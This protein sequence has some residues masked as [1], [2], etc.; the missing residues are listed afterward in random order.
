MRLGQGVPK[1]HR[2]IGPIFKSFFCLKDIKKLG[3][4]V[5]LVSQFFVRI[6]KRCANPRPGKLFVRLT[7]DSYSDHQINQTCQA[8]SSLTAKRIQVNFSGNILADLKLSN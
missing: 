5:I 1:T 4:A 8:I 6:A 7:L 3:A 2:C